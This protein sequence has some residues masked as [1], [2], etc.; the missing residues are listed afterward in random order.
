LTVFLTVD[1]EDTFFTRPRL[2]TGDG[3]G[4]EFGIHG[5]LDEFDAR[6]LRATFFVNVY[7][8]ERQPPGVVKTVVEEI[9]ARGHEVGLHSHQSPDL[10]FFDRP[11]FRLSLDQQVEVLR[12]GIDKLQTWA[13]APVTSFRAGGY[14]VNGATFEALER[15]AIKIDSSCYFR[16]PN[17]HLQ[18]ETVN[19]VHRRGGVIEVPVTSVLRVNSERQLEHR[20][21][22]I[23][24]LTPQQLLSGVGCLRQHG[25]GFAMVM[26]HSFSFLEKAARRAELPASERALFRSDA[27][28]GRVAEIYGGKPAMRAALATFLDGLVAD[29]AFS[30]RILRDALREL[31][32][33]AQQPLP[34]IVPIVVQNP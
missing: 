6:G 9:T 29:P 7:E 2:M 24:W 11:L 30:V 25:A 13:K 34:D 3:I 21:L 32:E 12:W 26:M 16:S 14:V 5:I 4:R 1:T 17:N 10:P 15:L 20:K 22:D 28:F 27:V 19:S 33:A 31:V 23:D 18:Y 8:C